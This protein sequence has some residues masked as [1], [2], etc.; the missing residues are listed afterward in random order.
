MRED[1][2]VETLIFK[3][4][5]WN[6]GTSENPVLVQVEYLTT[7]PKKWWDSPKSKDPSWRVEAQSRGRLFVHRVSTTM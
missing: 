3:E 5:I 1:A 6:C 7:T 2:R 4:S